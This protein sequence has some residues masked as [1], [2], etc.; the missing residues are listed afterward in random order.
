MKK[1]IP[2]TWLKAITTLYFLMII[3]FTSNAQQGNWEIGIGLR[4]LNLKDEPYTLMLKKHISPR[5]GLRFGLS[6][7]YNSSSEHF[8]Y[9]HPYYDTLYSFFIKY[10]LVD[11]KLYTSTWFGLQYQIG[12]KNSNSRFFWYGASDAFIKYR[13][14]YPHLQKGVDYINSTLRPGDYIVATTYDQR[15]TL[16]VGFR[17]SFGVQYFLNSSFSVATEAGFYYETSFTKTTNFLFGA[18]NSPSIGGLGFIVG[19]SS[20]RNDEDFQLGFSPVMQFSFN[21]HF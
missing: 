6:A 15:K 13:W 9:I 14:E 21:Y 8:R 18:L 5:V 19:P 12:R 2:T 17:Q 4:P 11:T 10:T 3:I 20:P 1:V 7:M 16:A